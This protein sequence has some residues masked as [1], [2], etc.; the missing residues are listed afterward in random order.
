MRE[1]WSEGTGSVSCLF[2]LNRCACGFVVEKCPVGYES[3]VFEPI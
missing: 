2:T 1:G 3:L